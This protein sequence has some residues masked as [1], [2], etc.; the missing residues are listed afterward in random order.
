[1]IYTGGQR[2][3][4]EIGTSLAD[5]RIISPAAYIVDHDNQQREYRRGAFVLQNG[6]EYDL[7]DLRGKLKFE[8]LAWCIYVCRTESPKHTQTH[9]HTLQYSTVHTY[10]T[11]VLFVGCDL[12]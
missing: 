12:Y 1:V 9:T 11:K 4:L 3:V 6:K 2:K 7:I 5:I 10:T 8:C